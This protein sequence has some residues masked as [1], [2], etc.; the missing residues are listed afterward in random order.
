[1]SPQEQLAAFYSDPQIRHLPKVLEEIHRGQILFPKFQRPLVW[2]KDM[3]LALLD[4]ILEGI[5]IGT[6]MVW[7]TRKV[8]VA[9]KDHLGAFHL[10]RPDKDA[11]VRQYLLDGEQRL[12]TLYFALFGVM[13]DDHI[14]EAGEAPDA[15]KVYYDLV[16][17]KFVSHDDLDEPLLHHLP[18][19]D[20]LQGPRLT[21]FQRS[22]ATPQ[23]EKGKQ[24]SPVGSTIDELVARSDEVADAFRQYTLP[25]VP[26]TSENLEIVTR[27]FKRVNSQHVTMSEVHMVN[28]LT[29][30]TRFDLFER[31]ARMREEGLAELG[32]GDIHDQTIL[33]VCKVALG[34][35]VY[36]ED[37]EAVAMALKKNP[38]V[39]NEVEAYLRSTAAFLR[40][41]CGIRSPNIVPYT[42]QIVLLAAA[43]GEV[44]EPDDGVRAR[45][46]DWLWLTTYG[47]IFQRQISESRFSQLL[48]DT[49]SLARGKVLHPMAGKQRPQ[50]RPLARFDFR[51]ARAR[52][53]ALLL[54]SRA[55]RDPAHPEREATRIRARKLLAEHGARAMAQLVSSSMATPE[56]SGR[57]GARVLLAPESVQ[58]MR[59]LLQGAVPLEFLESHVISE[60]A[61]HAFKAGDHG[62]F[63]R[64][65]E[66]DLNRIE[67]DRFRK[68]L[69]RLYPSN[70]AT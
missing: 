24:V 62:R 28:A 18:L 26:V 63:V 51:H 29:W 1:M 58:T 53:L 6:I 57:A 49:R 40:K 68:V 64:L 23:E 27:T 36:D 52:G 39:L 70:D 2:P 56:I 48:D 60:E 20:L 47:E 35:D 12:T 34:I 15:F 4:S 31:L 55:P 13:V 42:P 30:S 66:E 45:L 25:V 11:P 37:A 59:R 16:R 46:R 44:P 43:F 69:E 38:R 50:R 5:P 10:P 33:R 54:A 61:H 21:G 41:T 8:E 17:R 9:I 3:R 32:W 7:R 67:G 14:D 65:R 22:L 19:T